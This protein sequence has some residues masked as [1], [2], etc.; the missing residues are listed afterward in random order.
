MK[1][2]KFNK[3]KKLQPYNWEYNGIYKDEVTD[4][5]VFVYDEESFFEK[6]YKDGNQIENTISSVKPDEMLWFNLHGFNDVELFPEISKCFLI[7]LSTLNQVLSFSRRTRWEEQD[8]IMF[9]NLKATFPKLVEDK[10]QII[11]ISFVIKENQLF[12]FQEKKN[13]LF[14]HIRERIRT[15]TGNVRKKKRRLSF[16]FN[17]RCYHGELLFDFR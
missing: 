17:V 11:P 13:N 5:E 3:V 15:K 6:K 8:G 16:V 4:I 9:F 2:I 14:E 1:R 10:I 7:P 12:S